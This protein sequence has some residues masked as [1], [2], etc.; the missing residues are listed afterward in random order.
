MIRTRR[1]VNGTI[2]LVRICAPFFHLFL[3]KIP[4][5]TGPINLKKSHSI[6]FLCLKICLLLNI[7]RCQCNEYPDVRN[8][9]FIGHVCTLNY[10]TSQGK[11]PE[12]HHSCN[13]MKSLQSILYFQINLYACIPNARIVL[14]NVIV[15]DRFMSARSKMHQKLEPLPPG[16]QPRTKSPSRNMG[17]SNI[18]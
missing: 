11:H 1:S 13:F 18:A 9:Q 4:I 7:L 3:T 16:Q 2:I 8:F 5:R 17:S 10:R 15:I 12:R 14:Q 6:F